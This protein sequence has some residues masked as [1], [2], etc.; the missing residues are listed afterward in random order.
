MDAAERNTN[1]TEDVG[2]DGNG[3]G[4]RKEGKRRKEGQRKAE[5]AGKNK[6]PT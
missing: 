2:N 1:P 5:A 3:D 6:N 4:Y